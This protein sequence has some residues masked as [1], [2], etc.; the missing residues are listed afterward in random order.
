[1][2]SASSTS[3]STPR[4][5]ILGCSGTALTPEEAAFFRDLRPW[6]FILFKRN[7]G[8]PDAVRALT[9]AL[10]ETVGRA[11]APILI[12]QEGGRV[13]R[14]GPP[15]WP[16]Y[17]AG[18]R[19]DA[20]GDEAAAT[21]RLGARLMA[22]DLSEVGIN[23]DCAPMLDVPV[24]GSDNIIGDRAYGDTPG[25]VIELGRAVAE[26]LMAGGVL[27]VIKHIPG[28]GRAT[29]DSHLD[30]PVVEADRV[31]LGESD[32]RPFRALA[33]MPLA[34]SAHVVFN[35]LDPERPATLSERVIREVV[36]GEI[37]F[38]G[39]LMTDDLS[40]HALQGPFRDRAEAAYRAGIDVVLHCNGRMD[41]MRAVAEATP[42]LTGEGA[43]RAEAALARLAPPDAFDV[44]EAR[45]RFEAAFSN[46]LPS[47]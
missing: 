6:G 45:A 41:E 22:H 29:C 35:A 9:A 1:M 37:G 24:A 15:H 14:M 30:L 5:V 38:D 28:H 31:S 43:R 21:A 32:F 13:Q 26:G 3:A 7:I 40:M 47:A 12:D 44:T 33:D 27:P 11:D 34:M 39:L 17:P 19:F 42:D 25:R 8:T 10:R 16:K 2:I 4:A 18:G 46:T 20:L 36:R 23:V